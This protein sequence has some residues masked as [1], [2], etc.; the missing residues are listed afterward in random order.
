MQATRQ[1]QSFPTRLIAIV[2]ALAAL[3]L[4]GAHHVS[5]ILGKLGVPSRMQAARFAKPQE[6]GQPTASR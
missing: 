1:I 3:A 2:F 4:G 6:A 5:A